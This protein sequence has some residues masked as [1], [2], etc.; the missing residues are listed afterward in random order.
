MEVKGFA[1]P[2]VDQ[3]YASLQALS[4]RV[5]NPWQIATVLKDRRSLYASR[6]DW[7]RANKL[8]EHLYEL[9]QRVQA[10]H[11]LSVAH[12]SLGITLSFYGDVSAARMHLERAIALDQALE[13]QN[14]GEIPACRSVIACNSAQDAGDAIA[15]RRTITPSVLFLIQFSVFI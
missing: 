10:P 2:E 9:A 11:L 12:Q 8:G 4:E 3:A 13:P 6:S 15:Q 1:D 14:G 7:K 5:G